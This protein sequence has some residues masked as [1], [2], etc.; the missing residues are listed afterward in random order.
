MKKIFR[1]IFSLVLILGIGLFSK[2][3]ANTL[4]K[5]NMRTINL[6]G[7]I[8]DSKSLLP[9]ENANIYDEKGNFVATTDVKGYFKG[10]LNLPIKDKINFKIEVKKDGYI[11]YCQKE[12]W[13]DLGNNLNVVYYFGITQ[14]SEN[15]K[16]NLAFSELIS[17]KKDISYNA[18]SN[19]FQ[20]II[21]KITFNKEVE[22]A[23]SGNE[24][25]FLK[26]NDYYYL[27]SNTGW[28]KLNSKDDIIFID[29]NKEVIASE[30]N[31]VL[32]RKD[33]K[34]MTPSKTDNHSFEIFTK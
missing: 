6:A 17:N 16:N 25:V 14:Y 1:F 5:N 15:S 30:V 29:K 32:K 21:E 31:S 23:K 3:Y 9:I 27:I 4:Q 11:S 19:G 34:R 12:N 33:I 18:V 8:V 24:N 20:K 2:N 7:L 13:G 22:I 26:V 10:H 28:L